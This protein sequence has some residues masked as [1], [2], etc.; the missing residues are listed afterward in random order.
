MKYTLDTIVL[1]GEGNL[2]EA[3]GSTDQFEQALIEMDAH[4]Q[5]TIQGTPCIITYLDNVG[6]IEFT[7][8][9]LFRKDGV[10]IV[11]I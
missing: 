7:P 5:F 9:R 2:K 4:T 6:L 1:D 10:K 11:C 3:R 8:V